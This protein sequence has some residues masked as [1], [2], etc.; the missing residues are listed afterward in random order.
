MR[1]TYFHGVRSPVDLE[2]LR[3]FTG[4]INFPACV[5]PYMSCTLR[6]G[7]AVRASVDE[8]THV[9]TRNRNF[10]ACER[11][12]KKDTHFRN[13]N[14]SLRDPCFCACA[15]QV[16]VSLLNAACL[17]Q[18]L[19]QHRHLRVDCLPVTLLACLKKADPPVSV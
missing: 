12:R 8:E 17:Q 9:R 18:E 13:Q 10:V 15:L 16:C 7:S 19:L 3:H 14:T 4:I 11:Q 1:Q 2:K 5:N 6:K